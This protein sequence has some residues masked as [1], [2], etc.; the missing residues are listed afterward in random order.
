[1]A[2]MFEDTDRAFWLDWQTWRSH[3]VSNTE[4]DEKP[5]TFAEAKTIRAKLGPGLRFN[6]LHPA[7]WEKALMRLR[8]KKGQSI[9]ILRWHI[10]YP[11]QGR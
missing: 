4:D 8:G 11:I 2:T 6:A 1:M 5:L 3:F 7:K 10:A 9:A